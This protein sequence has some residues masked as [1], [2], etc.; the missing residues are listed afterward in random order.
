MDRPGP[1]TW[2]GRLLSPEVI[3]WAAV[4]CCVLILALN[5]F[6]FPF[7]WDDFDFLGRV[8][9][10][11]LRDLLP[12]PSVIFYRPLSREVYFWVVTHLLGMSPLAAHVLN[13]ALVAGTIAILMAF[14]RR[15]AGRRTALISGLL[16]ACSAALPLS[17]SWASASQDLLCALLAMAALYA[18]LRGRA[19]QS[20]AFLAAALLSKETAV[21]VIPALVALAVWQSRGQKRHLAHILAAQVVLVLVWSA[22]HP[23]IRSTLLG[24][25]ELSSGTKHEYLLPGGTLVPALVQG[26]EITLNIPW[27]GHAP[28]WSPHLVVP[29]IIV[30]VIIV[31]LIYRRTHRPEEKPASESKALVVGTLI[32]VSSILLTSFVLG[33]WS[34]HY[35]CMPAL[36]LAMVGGI[37]LARTPTSV[38]AFALLA[39]LWLG[40]GLRG[41]PIDP[42]L[43]TEANFRETAQAMVKV[44]RGFKLLHPT[45]P[46]GS[47]VFVSVQARQSGGLYRFLYRLQPLRIWY[48]NP[49]IWVLDPNRRR[50]KEPNEFLFWID[51]NLSVYEIRL[52]DLRPHGPTQ[53]ISLPQYQKTIRGYA[54]GL[55]GAGEVDR[56][57]FILA[58]MPETSKEV[59]V[60]DRRTAVALLYAAHRDEDAKQTASGVPRFDTSQSFQA[61]IALLAEPV[62]GL[63]LDDAALKAFD[64]DPSHVPTLQAIMRLSE[65]AGYKA[66]AGRIADRIQVLVPGDAES[67]A[68]IR[69]AEVK[70][71][72]EITVPI[73]HDIPQ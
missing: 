53:Q 5:V 28:A 35:V 20:L 66:A 51:P 67:A 16:F 17:I 2:P 9:T 34:T 18:Q 30:G 27:L 32:L 38:T 55:A 58:N 19:W 31:L 65:A 63:N 47:N 23:W 72:Q 29:A 8:N 73:P 22:I 52:S 44:E 7:L 6:R 13:T 56:A 21:S 62:I 64:L 61:V 54:M 3:D 43:P 37:G 39:F 14:M 60:F 57:V 50:E 11:R 4:V 24:G 10:L 59:A 41:N 69:R 25:S 48:R 33:G 42:I 26:L 45:L 49:S 46:P 15:L 1:R 12:D 68:V 40:I 70:A 71:P 36:G